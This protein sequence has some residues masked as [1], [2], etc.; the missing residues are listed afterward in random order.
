MDNDELSA[1]L[2]DLDDENGEEADEALEAG[3]RGRDAE[4]RLGIDIQPKGSDEDSCIDEIFDLIARLKLVAGDS[5]ESRH[6]VAGVEVDVGDRIRQTDEEVLDQEVERFAHLL[7]RAA[8]DELR[9]RLTYALWRER[10]FDSDIDP[11]DEQVRMAFRQATKAFFADYSKKKLARELRDERL[12][13]AA[14][15]SDDGLC[16]YLEQAERRIQLVQRVRPG[17]TKV[18]GM[19]AEEFCQETIVELLRLV[20]EDGFE[21][22]ERVGCEATIVFLYR[23]AD[24]LR[25]RR[26]IHEYFPPEEVS[27]WRAPSTEPSPEDALLGREHAERVADLFKQ[28]EPILLKRQQE[29]LCAIRDD[30]ESTG[31][32]N[33]ARVARGLGKH[34]SS[35]NRAVQ[36]IRKKLRMLGAEDW[37]E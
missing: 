29:W 21:E 1:L 20:R 3:T 8:R 15:R 36:A 12:R 16:L 33:E 6:R 27:T 32:I 14:S 19:D 2:Y 24:R 10:G 31:E 11:K 13:D 18:P 7:G 34:K 30:F 26:Q 4:S 22:H 37:L 35:A 17:K 28:L 25:K 9:G 5:Q 23:F